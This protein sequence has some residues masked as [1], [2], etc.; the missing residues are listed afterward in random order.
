MSNME[1][2]VSPYGDI[3]KTID[4]LNRDAPIGKFAYEFCNEFKVQVSASSTD[5]LKVFSSDGIRLGL[6]YTEMHRNSS[7]ANE[8]IYFF[9]SQQIVNKAKGTARANRNTRDANK[10][11]TLISNLKKNKEIPMVRSLYDSFKTGIKYAFTNVSNGRAPSIS[12]NDALTIDLIEHVL[13]DKSISH[14]QNQELHAY[15]KTYQS[16][17]KKFESSDQNGKRFAEGVRLVGIFSEG[18]KPHYLVGEASLIDKEV[19]IH[20][21]L[22]RYNSLKD[23][24]E[25]NTDVLMISTYMEAQSNNDMR[26]EF[27]LPRRDTYYPDIDVS[28]GYAGTELWVALP[29]TAP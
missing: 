15:Y 24:P 16:E 18:D 25:F 19:K 23:V 28:T 10:I 8:P 29:K 9:E 12:I 21:D 22:K 26:N 27:G 2:I 6:I 5:H 11:K 13:L 14:E 7:G 1:K 4:E 20:G 17:M 3:Q